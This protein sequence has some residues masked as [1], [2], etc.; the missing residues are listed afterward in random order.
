MIHS[1]LPIDVKKYYQKIVSRQNFRCMSNFIPD[2]Y[3]R[4]GARIKAPSH[5]FSSFLQNFGLSCCNIITSFL[6]MSTNKSL[7]ISNN[8]SKEK[9]SSTSTPIVN[10]STTVVE[11]KQEKKSSTST[12]VVN[13]ST[14]VVKTK[15]EKD[16]SKSNEA[17]VVKA[18]S[19]SF[20]SPLSYQPK[21]F[22]GAI[23][24][25]FEKA[26]ASGNIDDIKKFLMQPKVL[27][28][29]AANRN[30][31]MKTFINQYAENKFQTF[32]DDLYDTK[33]IVLFNGNLLLSSRARTLGFGA[34]E[35]PKLTYKTMK[36][37]QLGCY[38]YQNNTITLNKNFDFDNN[39]IE[40]NQE[41]YKKIKNKNA[42][43]LHELTHAKQHAELAKYFDFNDNG[44][45]EKVKSDANFNS[46][47]KDE[48]KIMFLSTLLSQLQYDYTFTNT[49]DPT[50]TIQ[51]CDYENLNHEVEARAYE[52]A[53]NNYIYNHHGI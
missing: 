49:C 17:S 29:L 31:K 44:R 8:K 21:E 13:C 32:V 34:N 6:G 1:V 9:K 11:Q 43:I 23:W 52:Q 12:P 25:D 19:I 20:T 33:N 2:T 51:L 38:T 30:S 53:Y 37:S 35:K 48:D 41:S 40:Q 18:K 46:I 45:L 4:T 22:I 27:N 47:V 36:E 14:P 39:K 7:R 50:N 5:G 28:R 15:K 24:E 3:M 42:T 10:Y 26:F 16:T